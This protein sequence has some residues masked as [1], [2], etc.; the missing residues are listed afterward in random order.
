MYIYFKKGP[1]G[2]V[3]ILTTKNELENQSYGS[4]HVFIKKFKVN[5]L[6][7]NFFGSEFLST[8]PT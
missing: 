6:L 2:P 1:E 8:E 4:R 3:L 5:I 7:T